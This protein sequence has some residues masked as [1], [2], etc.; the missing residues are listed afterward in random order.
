MR[1]LLDPTGG[2]GGGSRPTATTPVAP[3]VGD[4]QWNVNRTPL[5][6]RVDTRPGD[7][8]VLRRWPRRHRPRTTTPAGA[9][10]PDVAASTFTLTN[11]TIVM[12]GDN[13]Q[14]NARVRACA[15]V[16]IG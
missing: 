8:Y 12:D 15:R 4:G 7:S 3:A 13:L 9:G 16:R 14:F 6:S 11:A 1:L 5:Y 10:V 2:E